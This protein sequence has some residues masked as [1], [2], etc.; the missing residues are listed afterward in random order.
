MRAARSAATR[1]AGGHPAVR[2]RTPGGLLRRS[3][4][5]PAV[6]T[7]QP[8][9]D[10]STRDY[11]AYGVGNALFDAARYEELS[12]G[13]ALEELDPAQPVH[14]FIAVGD[15]EWPNPDPAEAHNDIDFESAQLYNTARRVPGITA[16][17]RIMDGGHDWDVWQPGFREGIVDIASRLRTA[18][19]AQWEAELFGAPGDDRAGGVLEHADGST[20]VVINA[21]GAMEGH[22][23]LGGL[24]IV[25]IRR[26]PDGVEQWRRTL[27]TAGNDRAYG[28]VEGADGRCWWRATPAGCGR[29]GGRCAVRRHRGGLAL[30]RRHARPV[31]AVRRPGGR[32]PRLRVAPDGAGGL[33]LTGYTSGRIGAAEPAGDKDNVVARVS[34][35][36]ELMWGDQFGG[37]GEDKGF[38]AALLRAAGSPS[39]GSRPVGCRAWR[40]RV[41]V[42]AGSPPTPQPAS[43]AG[44]GPPLPGQRAGQRR[45]RALRRHGVGD[46]PYEGCAG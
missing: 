21:D 26:G 27:G 12:Y 4:A 29:A 6:Y 19:A 11:G 28:V 15:D 31:P 7:P 35:D 5:Q 46:R 17:L 40:R 30:R 39:A 13:R 38:G 8:P 24:D 42:T 23:P 37:P 33:Y 9:A 16:E 20:T 3:R 25:V 43:E 41:P 36:A 2:A 10:S 45:R 18:P 22:E 14:L 1:W 32:R 44:C 34:G